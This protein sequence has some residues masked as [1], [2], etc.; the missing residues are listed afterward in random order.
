MTKDSFPD[1]SFIIHT[2]AT[3]TQGHQSHN[4]K[5]CPRLTNTESLTNTHRDIVQNCLRIFMK[6][7]RN[8]FGRSFKAIT[9]DKIADYRKGQFAFLSFSVPPTAF[10]HPLGLENHC[11]KIHK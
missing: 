7:F 10:L 1:N 2:L 6:A 9:N 11:G 8:V 4:T 3:K 5:R